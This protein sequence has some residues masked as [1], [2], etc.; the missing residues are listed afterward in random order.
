MNII[1]TNKLNTNIIESK[2]D[3]KKYIYL[4]KYVDA[5]LVWNKIFKRELWNGIEFP[6][7]K[8]YED[9]AV[10][11]KVLHKAKKI[12]MVKEQLYYYV[13]RSDNSS[14]TTISF[15]PKR[16]LRLDALETRLVYYIE[17][18]EWEFLSEAFFV[19]KTDFLVIMEHILNSSEYKMDMLKPYMKKYCSYCMK[20]LAKMQMPVKKKLQY[21]F[22][23][24]LPMTYYKRYKRNK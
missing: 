3:K 24:V 6:E 19:Y 14:V 2:Q 11:F 18:K 5:L 22:F 15:S 8:I 7:G 21:I 23:A 16:L 12:L 20:Y 13:K 9:E 10:T 1:N 17:N 4:E